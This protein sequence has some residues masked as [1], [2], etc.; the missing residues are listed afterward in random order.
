MYQ[1]TTLTHLGHKPGR[2]PRVTES[3]MNQICTPGRSDSY[4]FVLS[5]HRNRQRGHRPDTVTLEDT[6]TADQLFV[7]CCQFTSIKQIG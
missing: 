7:S 2:E 5:K 1:R 4:H 6:D 3:R